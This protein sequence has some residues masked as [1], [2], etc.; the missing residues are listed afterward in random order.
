MLEVWPDDAIEEL[1][2]HWTTLKIRGE[3]ETNAELMDY[4]DVDDQLT[5]G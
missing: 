4:L 3:V 2:Q 5:T 1:V